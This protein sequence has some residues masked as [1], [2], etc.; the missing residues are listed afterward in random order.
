MY[1]VIQAIR[2][3]EDNPA[4]Q[5]F[6]DLE[7]RVTQVIVDSAVIVGL[8]E[9]MQPLVYR[10]TQATQAPLVLVTPDTLDI[11][12][13]LVQVEPVLREL[14]VIRDFPGIQVS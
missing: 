12:G 9:S 4:I 10:G 8:Q 5:D 11:L 1:Q 7:Y 3:Q 6:R 14:R 2:D 13:L